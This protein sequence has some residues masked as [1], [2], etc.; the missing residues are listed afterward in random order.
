MRGLRYINNIIMRFEADF[1]QKTMPCVV[2]N[3][4]FAV[5]MWKTLKSTWNFCY[6]MIEYSREPPRHARY[7]GLNR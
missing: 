4:D 3:A 1:E 6:Y 7:M 5:K 2:Q